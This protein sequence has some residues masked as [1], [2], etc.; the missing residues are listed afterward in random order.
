MGAVER[1]ER[2]EASLRRA[3]DAVAVEVVDESYRHAGH[4]GASGGAGH[5]RVLV[6][7]ARFEGLGAVARQRLVFAALAAEM[8]AE[9][10]ALSMRTLTP[11]QWRA[12]A[13]PPRR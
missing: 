13:P 5:F 10:H 12:E 7:S 9:I 11:A 8:G 3:L 4:A 6:V 2:I 1:R